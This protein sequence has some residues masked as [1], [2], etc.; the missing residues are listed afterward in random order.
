MKRWKKRERGFILITMSILMLCALILLGGA[1]STLSAPAEKIPKEILIGDV[2]NYAGPY[3]VWGQEVTFGAKAAF[4]DINKQGGV[5][6]KEYGKKLP[7]KWITRDAQSDMLK[8]APLTEDLILR[9]KVNFLGPHMETPPMRQGLAMMAEKHKVPAVVGCGVFESFQEMRKTA[10][11]PWKY[12]WTFSFHIGAPYPKGDFRE[13]AP[14]Y[15]LGPTLF[16]ALGT[17]AD[18]TNKKIGL[19]A[20]DDPDGRV[21]Y[22]GFVDVAKKIGYDCYGADKLFGIFPMGTTDFTPL[23]Q[24]WKNYGVEILWGNCPGPDFGTLWRQCRVLGFKPKVV[25]AT[26]AAMHYFDIQS[27][28]GDLPQG[29][30]TEI[31][32]NPAIKNAAGIGNTTPQ[33]LVERWYKATGKPLNWGIGWDYL[34]AQILLH[35]IE[36]AGTLDREAVN[37]AIGE[38]DMKTIF[39]RVLFDKETQNHGF[40]CY[41]G[42]WRKTDKPWKWE[43]P[44]VFSQD[45]NMPTTAEVIFPVPYK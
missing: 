11:A 2:A 10:P 20:L 17:Y 9:E 1:Q 29:I 44:V 30:M 6:V 24:E 37:K 14:A 21:W 45:P 22:P 32:W 41:V 16:A 36:K 43:C 27:W 33:S 28:G 15:L 38:T 26:R 39:G 5:F 25:F 3:A 18:K 23:I 4:E 40:P 12:T 31:F 42:Q 8:V 35:A 7:V 19:F 13:N 34:G